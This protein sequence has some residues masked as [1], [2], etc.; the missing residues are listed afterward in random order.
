MIGQEDKDKMK[1]KYN[2]FSF[3]IHGKKRRCIRGSK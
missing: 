3:R 2:P 1:K